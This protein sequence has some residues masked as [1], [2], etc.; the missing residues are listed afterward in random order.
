MVRIPAF[1]ML[2]ALLWLGLSEAGAAPIMAADSGYSVKEILAIIITQVGLVVFAV[3]ALLKRLFDSQERRIADRFKYAEAAR[4]QATKH[5]DQMFSVAQATHE[6]HRTEIARVEREM[7]HYK[8][9]VAEN[10]VDRGAW[11]EHVGSMNHKLDV[12]RRLIEVRDGH[13]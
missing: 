7:L 5:W 1:S 13:E 6:S 8:T 10:Y 9:Y 12:I 2:C 4:E 3:W 11:L